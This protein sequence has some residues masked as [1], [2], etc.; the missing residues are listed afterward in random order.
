[1]GFYQ[2]RVL[3]RLI[4]ASMG[5]N[6]HVPYRRRAAARAS[7]RVLEIGPGS[8]LNLPFYTAAATEI[9]GLDPHPKLLEI[10][11][12][13]NPGIAWKALEGSADSIPMDDRSVDTVLTTW[14]LCSI[15][16]VGEA[17]GEARRVLKPGGKL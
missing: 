6:R 10:A 3:P 1:M 7:G 17:L 2:N 13:K 9:V 11:R 16:A 15:P 4:D 12:R 5:H 14:T 8:G